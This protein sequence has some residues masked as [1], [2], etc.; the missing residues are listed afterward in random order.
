MVVVGTDVHKRTHTFVAV[1]EHGRKVGDKVVKA[2]SEGH[3]AALAWA[4]TTFGDDLLWGVED[5]RNLSARLER[6]LLSAGQKVVRVAPKLMALQRASARTRGKS[7]P[8]DA[9]AVAHAVLRHPDLPVAA[10]DEVSRELKLLVDRREDLVAQRTS[11]I[12][13]LLGRIHELD[14]TQ[15]PKKASLD[16]AKTQIAVAAWLATI[17]GLL[18][19]L[20][21]DE[22]GDIIRLTDMIAA[23]TTRI[24]Q[25][26]H[27][28]APTLLALP[29]CGD[30]TAAKIVGE[31]AGITRFKSEAAFACHSG[32]APIPV[33]SG[34][35][36]GR[37]RLNR[38]GNRQLNAALYRIALTQIRIVGNPGHTYYLKRLAD[39]DS[40]KE[41]LR[42]LKR[43]LAR[44]VY[45]RL[46][47]DEQ[48]RNHPTQ[49]A[50][51]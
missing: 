25:A 42:C 7:D 28:A 2:T 20:A 49:T 13:R 23:L 37:V 31:T 33:W 24:G 21:N 45:N 4:K 1:D 36:T 26:V 46:Q 29:G 14:P 47:A 34:N 19:E 32:T 6:D 9:L 11:T 30:L 5:C 41:A 3:L 22:L 44:I 39:G 27:A 35:T 38:S 12:N 48:S 50:A 10:H 16:R 18:A 15:A 17:D 8:I 40:P 43:R 51:A